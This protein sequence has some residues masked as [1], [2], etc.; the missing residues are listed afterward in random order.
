MLLTFSASLF[1][2][3]LLL[4]LLD[5]C[6][7]GTDDMLALKRIVIVAFPA[8]MSAALSDSIR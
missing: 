7:W 4:T 3:G 1:V 8:S 6:P 5:R 2:A